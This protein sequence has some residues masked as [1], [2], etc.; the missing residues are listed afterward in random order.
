MASDASSSPAGPEPSVLARRAPD[1]GGDADWDDVARHWSSRHPDRLWREFTDRLQIGLLDRWIDGPPSG[2]G[3]GFAA[4]LKTD[5][6]DEIA[7]RGVVRGISARGFHV[8]GIDVSPVVV[9]EARRR[10]PDLDASVADVRALPFGDD[11]F[12]LVFSGS[13]LDHFERVEDIGLAMREIARVLR[14]GGRLVIT[15]D[16]PWNPIV[17][18]RNGP[19]LGPLRR[20]GIVPYPVGAT[21]GPRALADLVAASGLIVRRTTAILHCPR[22]LAVWRSRTIE[23]RDERAKERFLAVLGRWEGLE[24]WPTRSWTGH[25]TAILAAKP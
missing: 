17:W 9:A 14:P 11:A 23:N 8:T 7:G 25:L 4:A 13:T 22:V 5:L 16:T 3:A 2:D 10:V 20:R 24:R 1:T 15:L 18:L 21:L 19:L 12:D 6:F